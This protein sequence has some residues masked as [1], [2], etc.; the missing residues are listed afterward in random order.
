MFSMN[1]KGNSSFTQNL[2]ITTKINIKTADSQS[3][4][5]VGIIGGS[6]SGVAV[7]MIVSILVA[8]LFLKRRNIRSSHRESP[9]PGVTAVSHVSSTYTDLDASRR[10]INNYD[11]FNI[12]YEHLNASTRKP[13]TYMELKNTNVPNT[14]T[15][16]YVNIRI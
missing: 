15:S 2:Q 14:D 8:V 12:T 1:K 3:S 16:D 7:V 4:D 6:I 13:N 10:E 9:K 11:E 5:N